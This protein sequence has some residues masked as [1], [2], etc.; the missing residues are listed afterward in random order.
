MNSA[1]T[2]CSPLLVSNAAVVNPHNP[3]SFPVLFEIIGARHLPVVNMETY[4]I[5]Q[6]G[7]RTIHRT[8][9]FAPKHISRISRALSLFGSSSK[10]ADQFR[11]PIWTVQEDCILAFVVHPSD[12]DNNKSLKVTLWARPRA[13]LGAFEVLSVGTIRIKAPKI[14][15]DCHSE[16]TELQLM[17]ELDEP[18]L[19]SRGEPS[20]LAYRCRIAT[21]ADVKFV[22]KWMKVPRPNQWSDTDIVPAPGLPR[23]KLL[24]HI[25]EQDIQAAIPGASANPPPPGYVRVKPYPDPKALPQSMEFMAVGDLKKCTNMPSRQ[26][27][28]AGSKSSSIGRLYLEV[29]SAHRL[30]NVD[31]GSKVGNV[32]DA[33]CSIVYG[34]AMAQTDV[35]FDELSPH[36][37]PWTQ[38][39]FVFH[40]QHP[41]QVLYLAVFG[42]K[43]SPL[44]QHR[45]I[46]R[47]EVNPINL[48]NDTVYNLEYN[49]YESSHVSGRQSRGKLRI[50][51]RIEIDDERKALLAALL[52]PS[53]VYINTPKQKSMAVAR[54]TACGE[55]DNE[56][57]FSLQ[58]LQG[59]I[60]E[61][62]EGYVRRMLY[63]FQ[64]GFRSLVLWRNQVSVL[65]VGLPLFSFLAFVIGIV[66]VEKPGLIPAMIFFSLALLL[67]EQMN[68]RLR[69]PSPWRRCLSFLHYFRV[70]ILGRNRDKTES[71]IMAF[72]GAKEFERQQEA[73]RARIAK[74]KQ[75]IERKEAFE[76]QIEEIESFKL[77]DNSQPIP[78]EL[79]IVLGKVQSIV[80][81]FCRLCRLVD[82]I[83]TWE[84][85]DVAFWMTLALLIAGTVCIFIPWGWLLRWTVRF[86][87]VV[88][89]G[90]QNK[91][92]DLVYYHK[93]P[94]DDQR[95]YKIFAARM[96]EARCRQEEAGKLKTFRELLFGKFATLIPPLYWSPH[97]DFP[98][99]PSTSEELRISSN[100][101]PGIIVDNL[102]IIPG[103]TICGEIIPRPKEK[104]E[105]N[106]KESE[107]F[108]AAVNTAIEAKMAAVQRTHSRAGSLSGAFSQ[109]LGSKVVPYH[110]GALSNPPSEEGLEITDWFDEEVGFVQSIQSYQSAESAGNA[111]N[112]DASGGAPP[113]IHQFDDECNVSAS[114]D[115]DDEDDDA[116][117]TIL[118]IPTGIVPIPSH[119]RQDHQSMIEL[120]FEL[121]M[122]TTQDAAMAAFQ[123]LDASDLADNEAKIAAVT[124][125]GRHPSAMQRNETWGKGC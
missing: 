13:R 84:V 79:L 115:D 51:I 38:R 56:A 113:S 48:H 120:G 107:D 20:M 68:L 55:Y 24:T 104:W 91:V 88:F 59:Y 53:P 100:P 75:F 10:A 4:C 76:K 5:V 85:S 109:T 73:I 7:T 71:N 124:S 77:Q 87:V 101:P 67:L 94:T 33:F 86:V 92:F 52:P 18:I 125:A 83:I 69:S 2:E 102:P 58:V 74:D 60:D 123:A 30:P 37:P 43:R 96:F 34:D 81:D 45:A 26:W 117:S 57:K 63:S 23:A 118:H 46:G 82:A 119:D 16:R 40:M 114:E 31:I 111:S 8:K 90:P 93:I 11:D 25:P 97:Q 65:G 41:S 47:I 110:E 62:L 9:P 72:E 122:E 78:M 28:Q 49:L 15:E 14:L 64:D 32:T 42:F 1:P 112:L 39:A 35:I 106:M 105:K 89:L 22:E 50:R 27:V 29:L 116:D 12:I 19:D 61:I 17:T 66:I 95:I 21:H 103:Q 6:Y 70:L 54:Y 99:A 3:E 108:R 80:G 121:N 36:W 98:L 44:P